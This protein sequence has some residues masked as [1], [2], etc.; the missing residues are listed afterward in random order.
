MKEGSPI[1]ITAENVDS[2]SQLSAEFGFDSIAADCANFHRPAKIV[3]SPSDDILTQLLSLEERL[4][5]QETLVEV[6]RSDVERIQ[7]QPFPADLTLLR[8]HLESDELPLFRSEIQSLRQDLNYL[9]ANSSLL[10]QRIV[11]LEENQLPVHV[12][13]HESLQLRR[14]TVDFS[15][16]QRT[17]EIGPCF[18]GKVYQSVDPRDSRKVAVMSIDQALDDERLTFFKRAVSILAEFNHPT[19]TR[20]RGYAPY[21]PSHETVTG[22]LVTDFMEY[23]DIDYMVQEEQRGSSP[24]LWDDTAKLIVLYGTAVGMRMLHAHNVIHRNLNANSIFLDGN[25]EPHIG[26]FFHAKSFDPSDPLN[27]SRSCGSY[28]FMA[29]EILRDGNFGMPADIFAFSIL[30]YYVVTRIAPFDD[31]I[32]LNPEIGR[33]HV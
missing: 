25:L 32:R 26:N 1:T 15:Q 4:S 18:I 11:F 14:H 28:L 6:L 3:S 10:Y 24:P 7:G 29:P 8:S 2:I 16:F 12:P 20:L 31:Q 27:Q 21:V 19:I 30:A 23:R 13:S 22:G 17:A 9:S 33:A 5:R